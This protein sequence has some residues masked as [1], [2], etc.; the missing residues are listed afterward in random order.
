[1]H[2]IVASEKPERFVDIPSE[3]CNVSV[4]RLLTCLFIV[5]VYR[6]YCIAA[7]CPCLCVCMSHIFD[8]SICLLKYIALNLAP[9]CAQ[10]S[11]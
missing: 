6:Q 1:M 10:S 3:F 4:D 7:V 5:L 2:T 9:L 8:S 11:N